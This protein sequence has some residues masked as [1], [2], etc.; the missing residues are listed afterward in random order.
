MLERLERLM[1][2]GVIDVGDQYIR[3]LCRSQCFEI[4]KFR[5]IT[6]V[7][8]TGE[9][10]EQLC[11][12]VR[13]WDDPQTHIEVIKIL[14]NLR[15]QHPCMVLPTPPEWVEELINKGEVGPWLQL[16]YEIDLTRQDQ[17]LESVRRL[18][19]VKDLQCVGILEL[20]ITTDTQTLSVL[21]D[22]PWGHLVLLRL[23]SHWFHMQYHHL[24][25]AEREPFEEILDRI[26]LFID[27]GHCCIQA[28]MSRK[29]IEGSLIKNYNLK[30]HEC[31]I[32]ANLLMAEDD[33]TSIIFNLMPEVVRECIRYLVQGMDKMRFLACIERLYAF[34]S[35]SRVPMPFGEGHGKA[36]MDVLEDLGE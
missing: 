19:A 9:M 13:A 30:Q 34:L 7:V 10:W 28:N 29:H 23:K 35:S 26:A 15:A 14:Q 22:A 32:F 16:V 27:F 11:R 24:S 8:L 5:L 3:A 31:L 4:Q 17:L 2:S 25:H 1:L 20:P 21:K 18:V 36:I 12:H 33:D 6:S